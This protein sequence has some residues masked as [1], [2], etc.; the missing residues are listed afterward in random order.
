MA[1]LQKIKEYS[2]IFMILFFGLAIYDIRFGVLGFLCMGGAMAFALS[3]SKGYC[4]I[5]PRSSLLLK[6]KS[7]SQN[8]VAPPWL[9]KPQT[10]YIILAYMML[11]AIIGIITAEK[12]LAGLGFV[13]L[14]VLGISGLI[15]IILGVLYKPVTWCT[16]CP[17]TTI[18]SLRKK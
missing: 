15:S 9:F 6:L 18:V 5:C 16:I 11:M 2:W 4:K 17:I 10:K 12:T 14:R 3:G 1:R 8:K 7:I 13:M